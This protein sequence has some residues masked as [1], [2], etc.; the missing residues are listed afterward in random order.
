MSESIDDFPAM[1]GLKEF[2]MILHMGNALAIRM[3]G[4]AIEHEL[5]SPHF[6]FHGKTS[7]PKFTIYVSDTGASGHMG[8]CNENMSNV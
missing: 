7:G 1:G 6:G 3:S 8:N 4:L 5:A 2:D